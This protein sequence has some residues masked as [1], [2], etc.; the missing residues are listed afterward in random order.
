MVCPG[1]SLNTLHRFI[2]HVS[3]PLRELLIQYWGRSV[4]CTLK[5]CPRGPNAGSPESTLEGPRA[6]ARVCGRPWSHTDRV[7][8]SGAFWL[9]DLGQSAWYLWARFPLW[10]RGNVR[11]NLTESYLMKRWGK[12]HLTQHVTQS[13]LVSVRVML[14]FLLLK[15]TGSSLPWVFLDM[16]I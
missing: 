15:W 3:N 14:S 16:R 2:T 1:L 9:C 8:L 6:L 11:V 10:K 12:T 4:A 5:K 7:W 13:K